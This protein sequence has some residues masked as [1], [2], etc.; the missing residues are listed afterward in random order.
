M[1]DETIRVG[2]LVVVV[3][4]ACTNRNVGMIFRVAKV[5]PVRGVC[6]ECG[7][8]HGNKPGSVMIA[9]PAGKSRGFAFP[10]LKKINPPAE[11]S[12]TER[13]EEIA[14]DA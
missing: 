13:R 8:D 12:H 2:D 6:N 1:K 9:L 11:P 4:G 7:T 14:S 3:R 5:E 10:R